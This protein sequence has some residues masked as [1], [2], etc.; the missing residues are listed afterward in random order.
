MDKKTEVDEYIENFEGEVRK[1]LE[2][3]RRIITENAPNAEEEFSYGLVGYKLNGKPMV[4]FGGFP[5][6]VGFYATPVGHEAFAEEFAQYKQGKGS[7]QLPLDGPL[8]VE[9]IKRVVLYR[10]AQ[11][12]G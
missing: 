4:Y 7:V 11:L 9:L 6:H 12:G 5:K 3:M 1:R 2:T 10:V 8:P